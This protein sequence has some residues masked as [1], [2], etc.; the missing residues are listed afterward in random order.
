MHADKELAERLEALREWLNPSTPF[1]QHMDIAI[2]ATHIDTV[3]EALAALSPSSEIRTKGDTVTAP[4]EPTPDQLLAGMSAYKPPDKPAKIVDEIYRAM[5]AAA[6]AEAVAWRALLLEL[7]TMLHETGQD[8]CESGSPN[9]ELYS[10]IDAALT[11]PVAPSWTPQEAKRLKSFVDAMAQSD[12]TEAYH[13]IYWLVADRA[14][15]I[16]NPWAEVEARAAMFVN[17]TPMHGG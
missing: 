10:R 12:Y 17:V 5:L 4:T 15:D 1:I 8:C 13:Q 11:A 9:D 2:L 6:P 16:Y 3:K 7:R 14:A